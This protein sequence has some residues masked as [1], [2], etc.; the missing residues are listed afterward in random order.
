MIRPEQVFL[1]VAP[2][3]MRWGVERLSQHVQ[4]LVGRSPCDGTAY[5]FT[6]RDRIRLKL[7]IWDDIGVWLC[8]RRLHAG[9]F[10][11]LAPPPRHHTSDQPEG[12][13]MA[14]DRRLL[15]TTE[16]S[17]AGALELMTLSKPLP[18]KASSLRPMV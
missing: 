6:N 12:M 7:L 10:R 8:Q 5:A 3:D 2:L 9:R 18:N 13:A 1:A 14:G 11:W 16:C 15:A 17:T 4:Q